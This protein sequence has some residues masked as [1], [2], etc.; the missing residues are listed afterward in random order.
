MHEN[1][2][3]FSTIHFKLNNEMFCE[4]LN[5]ESEGN[6]EQVSVE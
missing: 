3:I 4:R 6:E 2:K 5:Y 1:K